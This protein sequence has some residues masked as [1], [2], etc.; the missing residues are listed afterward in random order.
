MKIIITATLFINADK[1]ISLL[2]ELTPHI[3]K[4]RKQTGCIRYE[5]AADGSDETQVNVLEEWEGASALDGHFA[6]ANFATIVSVIGAYD[7]I[8]MSARKY[9][10]AKES[11][12]FNSEGKPS[13]EF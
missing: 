13:S 8:S 1:R 2:D 7:I 10:I 5:W 9:G 11:P 6:G 3:L 4:V 12:V